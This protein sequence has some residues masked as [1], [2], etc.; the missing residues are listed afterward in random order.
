[1][2]NDLTFLLGSTILAVLL[3]IAPI[4]DDV[5]AEL[6]CRLFQPRV[7]AIVEVFRDGVTSGFAAKMDIG[8]L[9]AH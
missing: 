7:G 8:Q 5:V 6:A 3:P 9:G 4:V 2:T 1:M